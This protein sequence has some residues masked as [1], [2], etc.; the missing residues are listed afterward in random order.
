MTSFDRRDLGL[1]LLRLGAGG[2]LAAHGAQKLFGWFG[3]HGIEG[4]GAFMESVGYAPGK[5]SAT[6]A[7]LAETGGGAL[8]ALGL[9]TPAAGAAAAGAM[10]GATAIH[11]P[12]GFFNAEGGYEYAA[13]LGLAAAGLAITGPGR[14]SLDHAFRHVFDR[15][16]MVP[17]ALAGTAAVT[18]VVVG[19]RNQ[20]VRK[21][22]EG[23]QET[24]FEE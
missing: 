9:A 10:G 23:E 12:N 11:A 16:W 22:K 17:V 24:L 19:M 14:I 21:E 6:A 18:T 13:T 20:R 3:G 1:L 15:G 4:T 2:V 8:L 7:G 5:A